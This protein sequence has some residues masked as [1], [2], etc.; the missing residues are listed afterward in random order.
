M[1]MHTLTLPLVTDKADADLLEK[2]FRMMRHIHNELVTHM[3]HRLNELV[4]DPEYCRLLTEY[5]DL[6]KE[7]ERLQKQDKPDRSRIRAAAAKQKE[8]SDALTD[9]RCELRAT[10]TECEAFVKP[11]QKRFRK[12]ISS[13]QAQK[14]ADFVWNGVE[15]IL[16]GKGKRLH[17]KGFAQHTSLQ[18][19][20]AE[21]GVKFRQDHVE[22]LGMSI[23]VRI[24]DDAYITESLSH[25]ISYCIITR[26]A[27]NTGWRYY[28]TLYLEGNAPKKV[29]PG[30]GW[31]GI[32]P[33]MSTMCHVS[34]TCV[35]FEE[36]APK[37]K[38]YNRRIA[39]EQRRIDV[40]TRQANPDNYN[41]D[42][43]VKKG[44][45]KWV[46]TKNCRK[47]KN[48]LRTLYR[49]K[50]AYT[51][52]SHNRILNGMLVEGASFIVEA[53]DYAALAKRSKKPAERSDKA[54]EVKQK[55]G[56]VK[57]VQK[58]RK[59]RRFGKSLNDRSPSAFL[60]RAEQKAAQ[61][62]GIYMEVDTKAFR[63]SQYD[64]ADNTYK[65]I[66]L[67]QRSKIVG[68][69][70]VLRDPYSAFLLYCSN[71]EG[72]A[73]DRDMC[74]FLFEKFL[75]MQDALIVFTSGT[76]HTACFGY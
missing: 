66:P 29:H 40:E 69:C 71:T 36:L 72:T 4:R 8:V 22:W 70:R 44:R 27:F 62:G 52:H 68:G 30:E 19:K 43:T 42:G 32:D 49:K 61:Y 76:P 9:R 3:Q 45:R 16:F 63:A 64:H 14:E 41:P 75:K 1:P 46:I 15:K 33:G 74:L 56:S 21:N 47:R 28:V 51:T 2:R 10:K 55:D 60:T 73:P 50:S 5:Q 17:Y 11:M 6:R 7:A 26:K 67:S 54:A 12:H 34:E 13:Q 38:D 57:S 31:H 37:C 35:G 59:K 48:R 20:S 24:K 39:K 53:M 65:K 25:D 18:Q 23:P 58:Y